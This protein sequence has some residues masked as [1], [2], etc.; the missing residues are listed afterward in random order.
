MTDLYIDTDVLRCMDKCFM[1]QITKM[2]DDTLTPDVMLMYAIKA[3]SSIMTS[4]MLYNDSNAFYVDASGDTPISLASR[5]DDV[6]CLGIIIRYI[7]E[8]ECKHPLIVEQLDQCVSL[9]IKHG[10]TDRLSVL[11]GMLS[12]T[13]FKI[14]YENYS[15]LI[16]HPNPNILELLI[17]SDKK[18]P[19]GCIV[20]YFESGSWEMMKVLAQSDIVLPPD[21]CDSLEKMCRL[22][23]VS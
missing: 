22:V 3:N 1:F 2:I 5:G 12:H 19:F 16:D 14:K 13:N 6:A 21:E 8:Y 7:L 18:V 23:T 11:L 10:K 17:K 15:L 4:R 9:L 20:G